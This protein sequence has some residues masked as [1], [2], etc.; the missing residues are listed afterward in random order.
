MRTLTLTATLLSSTML[1][2]VAAFVLD[3]IGVA[4]AAAY[5]LRKLRTA[6]TG[7]AIRYRRSNDNVEADIGFDANGNLDLDALTTHVQAPRRPLTAMSTGAAAAFSLRLI[8]AAYTGPAIRVRRSNDNAEI[9]IG[10]TSAG[11]L[12]TTALLAFVGANSA[13]VTTW[14]D[15]SGNARNAIQTTAA[16]QPRI[17]NAG[18]VELIGSRPAINFVGNGA[19]N[20]LI[21]SGTLTGS[22]WLTNLV[23]QQTTTTSK[24]VLLNTA[25]NWALNYGIIAGNAE[26]FAGGSALFSIAANLSSPHITSAQYNSASSQIF[27]NGTG[28]ALANAGANAP[29][30]VTIGAAIGGA[31][32]QTDFDG[33]IAEVVLV[34][35]VTSATD[36]TLLEQSQAAYY[37]ITYATTLPSGFVTTW[38]DQ[39]GNARNATQTTAANQPRIVNAGVVDAMGSRPGMRFLNAFM[40]FTNTTAQPLT[41]NVVHRFNTLVNNRHL[42]DGVAA[43]PRPLLGVTTTYVL[44]AGGAVVNIGAASTG[45]NS[46]ATAIFNG[47][48]S[49]GVING[50]STSGN[51][52]TN[53]SGTV[54][55]G[56]GAGGV[57]PIPMDGWIAEFTATNV[58]LATTD[59]QTLERN[60]GAYYGIA[61]A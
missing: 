20:Y 9:D 31:A 1:T 61:V 37:G 5:S 18:V 50:T 34:S 6:Y 23:A 40:S 11:D 39:S 42:T 54:V 12:N 29:G 48:S 28:S 19:N 41:H 53:G 7:P 33:P 46:V 30:T 49:A 3:Q 52:G 44:F 59:R 60:Q 57:T 13:F 47:A 43:A 16:N 45:V 17:V 8:R 15:Q 38:Y 24:Y 2:S 51:P 35:G 58:A 32:P 22:S 36:R 26:L 25:L 21:I 55:L 10:F 14:Y 27:V 56:A 4:A